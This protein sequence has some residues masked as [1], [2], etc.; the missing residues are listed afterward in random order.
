LPEILRKKPETQSQQTDELWDKVIGTNGN[1]LVTIAKENRE[2]LGQMR[3]DVSWLRGAYESLT[4]RETPPI[5]K[6]TITLRRLLEVAV[7]AGVLSVAAL[8]TVLILAGRL[9]AD[10]IANMLRAW[11]GAP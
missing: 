4:R 1:G 6:K 5:S 3:E 9:D 2:H 7:V 10:D 8:V 11:K